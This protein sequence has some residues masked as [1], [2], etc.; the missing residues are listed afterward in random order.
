MLRIEQRL[1]CR[2]ATELFL[3]LPFEQRQRSRLRVVLS[4]G[5]EAG[6]FLNRGQILRDGDCLCA[7]D[8]RVVQVQASAES[9][10]QVCSDDALLLMRAAYHLG[11]RHVPLQV[12]AMRLSYLHDHVL[13][14]M[15]RGL[16]LTVEYAL[17]PFEPESGAYSGGHSHGHSHSL[18]HDQ[19]HDHSH[20]DSYE[21]GHRHAHDE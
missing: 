15:V 6:L 3:S 4:N 13:D 18:G 11:N 8:G 2:C 7:D 16:G 20:D 21:H 9:V 1:E 19:R 14:D 12:E 5:E 17:A 10:S